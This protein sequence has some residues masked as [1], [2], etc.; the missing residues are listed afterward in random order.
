MAET[1]DIGKIDKNLAT[2]CESLAGYDIYNVDSPSF[3]LRGMPW[4]RPGG[5]FGRFAPEANLDF[6][7]GV[8]S[9]APCTTGAC[10]RFRTNATEVKLHAIVNGRRMCHMTLIGSMGFDLYV[11]TG[12]TQV[13]AQSTRFNYSDN[14][15][16]CL[17]FAA[18]NE[19]MR[20]FTIYFPLYSGVQ[21]VDI[22]LTKGAK[23]E[24]PTPW[25]DNRPIV[26][27]GTSITQGGCVSR[28]GMLYSNILSRLLNRPFYNFGF[29][30]NGKGEP[31]IARLL[32]DIPEEPAMYILDYDDNAQ[33]DL[34]EKTLEPFIEILRAKHPTTP[35][36]A[37]STEPKSQEAYNPYAPEGAN[38]FKWDYIT[39][40]KRYT[41]IHTALDKKLRLAGDDNIYFMD[42]RRLYGAD[43][44]ECTVD[45]AHS[46]DL[47]AYRIAHSLAPMVERILSRWW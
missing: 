2:N 31:E 40:R 13:F 32:S 34:L 28:P 3:E 18:H 36:L 9:L 46:T 21:C 30:G 39:H 19:I 25:I 17:L 5:P 1:S 11:G 41:D 12:R 38:C 7:Q 24:A 29:S 45:G 26:V 37:L 10:L 14:E 16:T 22:G 43:F 27:Y 33:P 42:G 47:G 20:D 15:Y 6:S 35:I 23:V 44:E 8:K 4:R